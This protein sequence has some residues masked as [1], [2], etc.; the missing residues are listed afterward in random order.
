MSVTEKKSE[1][2]N[3]GEVGEGGGE[4]EKRECSISSCSEV[5][6]PIILPDRVLLIGESSVLC[7]SR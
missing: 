2:E 1:I 5:I 7:I 4:G 3:T 6:G